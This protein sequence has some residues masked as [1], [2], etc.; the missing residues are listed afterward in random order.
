VRVR[1]MFGPETIETQEDGSLLVRT[2]MA[3]DEWL[4]GMLLSYGDALFVVE[5]AYI[6]ERVWETIKKM[7]LLYEKDQ[8]VDR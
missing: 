8:N 1:D 4:H 3:D 5:P 7:L 6:R 2:V